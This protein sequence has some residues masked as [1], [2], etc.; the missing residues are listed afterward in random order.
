MFVSALHTIRRS[1]TAILTREKN[2]KKIRKEKEI[3]E[4]EKEKIPF[5]LFL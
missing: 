2:R 3:E 4:E 5:I 1:Y